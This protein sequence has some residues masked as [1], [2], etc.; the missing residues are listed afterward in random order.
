MAGHQDTERVRYIYDTYIELALKD[1]GRLLTH[2]AD[3]AVIRPIPLR[4]FH[5]RRYSSL[6]P[7]SAR[8]TGRSKLTQRARSVEDH[9][10]LVSTLM[11]EGL[12]L[13]RQPR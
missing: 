9:A 5:P 7:R 11:I 3:D 6:Q 2:L 12:R 4:T 8:R 10:A 1:V 13:D